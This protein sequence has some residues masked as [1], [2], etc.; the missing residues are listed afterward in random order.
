MVSDTIIPQRYRE[1][2]GLG[3]ASFLKT[4]KGPVLNKRTELEGI[5]RDGHEFPIELSIGAMPSAH[6]FVFSAFARD[7]SQRRRAEEA[8]RRL[9]AT[10]AASTDAIISADLDGIII[11]WN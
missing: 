9:A 3:L 7:I 6:G 11:S 10:V 4:G 1:A 8:I 2:H 5:H